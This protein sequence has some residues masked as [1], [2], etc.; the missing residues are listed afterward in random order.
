[1]FGSKNCRLDVGCHVKGENLNCTAIT[2]D[3]K[4][5]HCSAIIA[6]YTHREWDGEYIALIVFYNDDKNELQTVC[7][8]L[9]I[10]I[11]NKQQKWKLADKTDRR[12]RKRE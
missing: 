3:E 11:K 1:M 9:A 5:R 2:Y 6:A 4:V 8:L 10:E 7:I 12:K